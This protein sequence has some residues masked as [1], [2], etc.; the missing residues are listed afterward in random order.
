MDEQN[1]FN[2]VNFYKEFAWKLVD[3]KDN[4]AELV[5]K[6]KAIYT[7]TKIHMPTLEKDN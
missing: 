5:E 7:K 4:R 3:Y 1:Q 2:W 6:V